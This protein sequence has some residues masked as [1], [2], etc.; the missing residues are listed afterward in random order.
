[1]KILFTFLIIST[2]FFFSFPQ[3]EK[4]IINQT[5]PESF[6][7]I[8]EAAN[9]VVFTDAMGYYC[10]IDKNGEKQVTSSTENFL[11]TV[12]PGYPIGISGS[13]FEGGILCNMDSDGDLE[14]VYNIGYSIQA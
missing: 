8:P 3:S 1:M 4:I 11:T 14:I 13:S 7:N 9:H 6:I 5:Q 12:F 2:F 10:S